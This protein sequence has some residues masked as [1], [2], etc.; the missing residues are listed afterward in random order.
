MATSNCITC[1]S[2]HDPQQDIYVGQ[3]GEMSQPLCSDC[4]AEELADQTTLD[5]REAKMY[6]L[7][8]QGLGH[9]DIAD[10]MGISKGAVDALGGRIKAKFETAKSTVSMLRE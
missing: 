9:Q 7:K 10:V 4:R 8:Q 3:Y 2:P 6:S 1:G 5:E